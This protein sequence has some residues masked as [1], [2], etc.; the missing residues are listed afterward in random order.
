MTDGAIVLGLYEVQQSLLDN[1][2]N[3][4]VVFECCTLAE[5]SLRSLGLVVA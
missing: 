4:A 2:A 3:P 5:D 1:F